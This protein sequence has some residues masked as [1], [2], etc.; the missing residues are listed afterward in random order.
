VNP[1]VKNYQAADPIKH[2]DEIRAILPFSGQA[3]LVTSQDLKADALRMRENGYI[4]LGRSKFQA[5]PINEKLA[6]DQA[7]K[8]GAEVVMVGHKFVSTKTESL[9]MST[10]IPGQQ[11]D[12][13]ERVVIQ[14][15]KGTPKVIEHTV[16]TTTQGE[17]QTAYVEQSTDYYDYS[18]S[19]WVKAK[20]PIFGVHVEPLDDTTKSELG[21]QKGVLVRV[22]IKD[23]PAYEADLLRG[24]V[25]LSMQDEPIRD[26]AQF[27]TL[28][29]KYAGQTVSVLLYR[30]GQNL[31]K[32][33]E[34]RKP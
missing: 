19:Y 9:P 30:A 5:S 10:W 13:T 34:I 26:P 16:T 29:D 11:T 14:N 33:V 20:P 4:L 12:Q 8:I 18:A 2:P 32:D 17:Y 27:F 1:Y 24:D 28:V 31:S 6:L 15:G 23:S 25:L 3:Q 7:L 22:V 21:T